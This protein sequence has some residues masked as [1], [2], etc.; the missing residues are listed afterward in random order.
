VTFESL[1]NETV[2]TRL[3]PHVLS[4]LHLH[5]LWAVPVMW[6]IFLLWLYNAPVWDTINLG[7]DAPLAIVIWGAG[8]AFIGIAASIVLVRW[9]I[10]FAYA[11]VIAIG[12][13]L[14][15]QLGLWDDTGMFLPAYTMLAFLVG[16]PLVEI[17][18]HTHSY[19]LTD[20][21]IVLQGGLL[22]S[23]QRSIRYEKI[24]D[25]DSS[26]GI[27]GKLF[28]FGTII[29]ITASGF[30]MGDDESFA[31][32]GVAASP[33]KKIGFFGFAGGERGVNTPRTRSYYELHGI[34]PYRDVRAT[35]EELVQQSSVA[36]YQ[37]EQISL[38]REILDTLRSGRE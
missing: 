6:S 37:R 4:F 32:G 15:W 2:K 3:T 24:S 25:I 28:G 22:R 23:R 9:R 29:P 5:L 7:L 19:V 27:L 12:L 20:L 14:A 36:P 18:R 30:G 21:R 31:G 17:Y 8:L 11:A 10:F 1:D 16:L 35:L 33:G 38:Q 34:H 26:Q 13:V